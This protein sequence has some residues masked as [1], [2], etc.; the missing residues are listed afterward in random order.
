MEEG[1]QALKN[2]QER[3]ASPLR[4]PGGKGKVANFLKLLIVENGLVG[5][6]YVEPYA[7]GASA[8][9]R[10]L[11]GRYVSSIQINDLND[12]VYHFWKLAVEQPEELCKRIANIPLT[13]DEW[14]RQRAIYLDRTAA[15]TD[16]AFATFYLNRTNRSGIIARGGPIG[17]TSQLGIW[18][19]GARFN[20]D[21]LVERVRTVATYRDKITVTRDDAFT[22]VTSLALARKRNGDASL[23]YLD[24]PY[25]A[26]GARLYDNFYDDDD[27][28]R[29]AG[30]LR[31]LTG[32]WVISYDS[33]PNI[34]E[35]YAPRKPLIYRLGYSASTSRDG[36]EVMFFSGDLRIPVVDSPAGILS[37]AV[38]Y[39]P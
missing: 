18:K 38:R 29:I 17:G 37:T 25:Y 2:G 15:P 3:Y 19:L 5:S 28:Q 1:P 7:G 35:M 39:P 21:A 33:H 24:P 26:K 34:L 6:H 31:E 4:Y 12:G 20:R 32:P 14:R 30:A 10:L 27:H 22:L 9:L 36:S 23:I 13:I 11:Y 16:H 8:A